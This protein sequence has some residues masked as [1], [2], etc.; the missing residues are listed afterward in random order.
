ML[1]EMASKHPMVR[2]DILPGE[3][4]MVVSQEE[5]IACITA[6]YGENAFL[7][8]SSGGTEGAIYYI[9]CSKS[10]GGEEE[11]KAKA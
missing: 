9:P 6:P 10:V 11:I 2:S 5:R 8:K 4:E 7:P 3:G 1:E